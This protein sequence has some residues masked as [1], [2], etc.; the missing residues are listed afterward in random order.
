MVFTHCE[1]LYME[2]ISILTRDIVGAQHILNYKSYHFPAGTNFT[3]NMWAIH[4]HPRD[5][6]DPDR[7]MPE[8]FL[9]GEGGAKQPYPTKYGMNPIG[10]GR[11][12]CSGQPL[13]EQGLLFSLARMIWAFNILPGLD[14]NVSA[15]A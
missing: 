6:P 9:D 2:G 1:H 12:Q 5:F 3:G 8:R 10:W 11:R 15:R 4:R 7:F 13:A 14:E